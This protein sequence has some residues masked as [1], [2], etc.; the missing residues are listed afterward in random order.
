MLA[1]SILFIRRTHYR[2]YNSIRPITV[3]EYPDQA[4]K[5]I[6]S[7]TPK[8]F[9]ISLSQI[10]DLI[11]TDKI[12]VDM[13]FRLIDTASQIRVKDIKLF[14]DFYQQL[15]NEFSYTPCPECKRLANLL[16]YRG[17][18]FPYFYPSMKEEEVL[19]IYPT[20]SPLY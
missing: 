18:R 6:W 1:L 12:S 19:N 20:D 7:V 8:K 14:T 3:L 15:S 4:S 9:S 11:K 17:F 13:A 5:V 10:K 2:T 16:Y